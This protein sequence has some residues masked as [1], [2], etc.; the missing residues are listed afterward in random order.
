M[1]FLQFDPR[2]NEFV[3]IEWWRLT[4]YTIQSNILMVVLYAVLS[5]RDWRIMKAGKEARDVVFPGLRSGSG[6]ASRSGGLAAVE[7]LSAAEKALSLDQKTGLKTGM[8]TGMKTRYYKFMCTM[9]VAVTGIVW[10]VLIKDNDFLATWPWRRL[11]PGHILHTVIPIS[12][13]TDWLLFD[14]KGQVTTGMAFSSIICPLLYMIYAII[15]AQ[16][17]GPLGHYSDG[18]PYY[19]WYT[20][21]ETTAPF[22][23]FPSSVFDAD[24]S[25]AVFLNAVVLSTAIL[26]FAFMIKAI[27]EFLKLAT[28]AVTLY[29]TP[30]TPAPHY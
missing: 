1:E 16:L 30:P 3:S 27:D 25:F 24:G 19:Y 8:K 4:Y 2:T 14:P 17:G 15:R 6:R 26:T 7:S 21:L 13:V 18:T 28:R 5:R 10:H 11:I 20:F 22:K 12:G 23:L 29:S 9:A